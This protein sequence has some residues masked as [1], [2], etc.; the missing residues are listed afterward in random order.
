MICY[1]VLRFQ[2]DGLGIG[3]E[4]DNKPLHGRRVLPNHAD[5]PLKES[6]YLTVRNHYLL[7]LR[8]VVTYSCAIVVIF[9]WDD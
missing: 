4:I 3:I 9:P 6:R 7:P 5:S 8:K 1:S 2:Y